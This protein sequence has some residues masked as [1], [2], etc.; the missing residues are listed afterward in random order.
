[1]INWSSLIL[2]SSSRRARK[3]G[4]EIFHHA[5]RVIAFSIKCIVFFI[6]LQNWPS[7]ILS[8]SSRHAWKYGLE[9]HS[10]FKEGYLFFYY[11][12]SFQNIS[13]Q[14]LWLGNQ[15]DLHIRSSLRLYIHL[16]STD[17]CFSILCIVLNDFIFIKPIKSANRYYNRF[18]EM[19]VLLEIR[20]QSRHGRKCSLAKYS[21]TQ[22]LFVSL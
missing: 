22:E 11:V 15:I 20:F 7:L 12:Y 14:K 18:A 19:F 16:S 6:D 3:H 2:S 1:M 10:P 8:N 9:S 4:S 5:T 21:F 13:H 17:N